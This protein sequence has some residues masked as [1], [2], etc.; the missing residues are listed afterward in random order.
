MEA[1]LAREGF[2]ELLNV[3]VLFHRTRQVLAEYLA[4]RG[5]VSTEGV[6]FLAESSLPH[7]EDI[8]SGFKLTLRA[9]EADLHELRYLVRNDI[10]VPDEADR[11]RRPALVR[12]EVRRLR[13]LHHTKVVLGCIPRLPPDQASY[14]DGRGYADIRAPRSPAELSERIDEMERALWDV[15][16]RRPPETI[17]LSLYRRVYGFFDTGAWLSA[18]HMRLFSRGLE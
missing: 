5:E 7:V 6:E 10:P 8:R 13:A 17:D 12:P 11:L 9:S 2:L 3:A 1:Y 15:A 4:E 14:P 16:T 18:H